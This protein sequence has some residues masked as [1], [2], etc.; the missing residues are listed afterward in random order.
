[1]PSLWPVPDAY[2]LWGILNDQLPPGLAP[3]V[4]VDLGGVTPP[5]WAV[6]GQHG[7][8][9][10]QPDGRGDDGPGVDGPAGVQRDRLGQ[11][12]GGAEH[13]G[14]GDVLQDQ[15]PRVERAGLGR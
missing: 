15:R 5:G 13:T 2:P 3:R 9:L 10:L 12:A 4:D 11:A 1:M 14:R 6:A 8:Y 7:G